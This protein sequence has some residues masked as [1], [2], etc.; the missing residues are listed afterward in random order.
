MKE[1]LSIEQ[2]TNLLKQDVFKNLEEEEKESLGKKK[3][4]KLAEEQK[5]DFFNNLEKQNID[6]YNEYLTIYNGLVQDQTL[7][8]TATLMQILEQLDKLIDIKKQSVY[9]ED[10]ELAHHLIPLR[11]NIAEFQLSL[12]RNETLTSLNKNNSLS[13]KDTFHNYNEPVLKKKHLIF[14]MNTLRKNRV[15]MNDVSNT[16]MAK[17]FAT[18]TGNSGEQLRKGLSGNPEFTEEDKTIIR[19]IL[20]NIGKALNEVPTK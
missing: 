9:N 12:E 14:L 16:D 4:M 1:K 5:K 7:K 13:D 2:L 8:D 15:F 19:S 17:A 11:N 3:S 20:D 18:L 10:R 6:I